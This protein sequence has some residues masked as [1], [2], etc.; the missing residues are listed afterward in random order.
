VPNIHIKKSGGGHYKKQKTYSHILSPH[1]H[2]K[3]KKKPRP[4]IPK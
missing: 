1:P 2:K 3:K 4:I